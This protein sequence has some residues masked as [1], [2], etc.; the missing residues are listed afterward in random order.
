MKGMVKISGN[1]SRV[2]VLGPDSR[3]QLVLSFLQWPKFSF[4]P[5]TTQSVSQFFQRSWQVRFH[6][7]FD[8]CDED[9]RCVFWTC[10]SY[11]FSISCLESGGL[12]VILSML[13][14]LRSYD[15]HPRCL[16]MRVACSDR[17]GRH[18]SQET[19]VVSWPGRKVWRR[20]WRASL[21]ARRQQD[22]RD[23]QHM[24][25]FTMHQLSSIRM[26]IRWI[27]LVIDM[28]IHHG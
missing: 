15:T 12:Q 2:Y 6:W 23:Y 24:P 25:N 1:E 5:T 16:R 3:E 8:C 28:Q 27:L 26:L 10:T 17:P 4:F 9:S 18:S 11:P 21:G 19:K 22:S 7:L 13:L 14:I 20:W